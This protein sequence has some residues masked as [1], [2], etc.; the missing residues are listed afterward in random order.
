VE[1]QQAGSVIAALPGCAMNAD[2]GLL[3][4]IYRIIIK[5]YDKCMGVAFIFIFT[6]IYI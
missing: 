2:P 5:I 6:L 1:W 4:G 3:E